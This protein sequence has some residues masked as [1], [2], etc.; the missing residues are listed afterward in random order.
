MRDRIFS[1]VFFVFLCTCESVSA[2]GLVSDF[3]A[4]RSN[5]GWL[6]DLRNLKNEEKHKPKNTLTRLIV[7]CPKVSP[8]VLRNLLV[9]WM[10]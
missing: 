9:S 4:F 3:R 2:V 5:S 7:H 8:L 1:V 10:I 6:L